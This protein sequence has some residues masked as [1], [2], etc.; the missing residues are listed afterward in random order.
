MARPRLNPDTIDKI[1]KTCQKTFTISFYLR[2]KRTYC[3]K[4]CANH[5]PEIIN[6]MVASQTKTFKEKYGMHPMKTEETKEN[7]KKSVKATHGVEWASQIKGWYDTVKKNNLIKHGVEHY[8]NLDAIKKTCMEK[9]GV[10]NYMQ[11]EEYMKKYKKTCMKKY[12]V[13]HASQSKKFKV[14]HYKNMFDK[15][16]DHPKF[17]NFKPL[18]K[19]TEYEGAS[20]KKYGFECRRCG[21]RK[22]HTL[23]CGKSP[24]CPSCDKNNSSFFQK[25]IYDFINNLFD[26]QKNIEI[27]DRRILSPKEIDIV[28]PDICLGIE[29]NGLVW[30]SEVIGRKQKTYHLNKNISA[31]AK[32]YRLIHV[33]ENE[34]YKKQEILKSMFRS[35]LGKTP[36]RIHG[37]KCTIKTVHPDASSKF[38]NENHIQGVDHSSVKIGLY[39]NNELVSLMTFVKSRFDKNIE[40][41]L[42]RFCNKLNTHVNGGASKLLSHF[43]KIYNPNNIVSYSD[44]RYFDGKLYVNLGFRFIANTRP[45]YFYIIDNYQTLQ[46]R[47]SWQ[48]HLLH[49][50]LNNFDPN[51][52]EWENMKNNGFDRIWDCGNSKWVWNKEIIKKSS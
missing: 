46:N 28:I 44:R 10:K 41:E 34:W 3:S 8:N 39:M 23:D 50:N 29:C 38:L 30:H 24:I 52:T 19:F 20:I 49:K 9:Y 47:I 27:N 31:M 11:T 33:F 14:T 2:N 18:F 51:L 21:D 4:K 5:D 43:I 37:R 36:D 12:G 6:K 32:G 25:E 48:K 16:M 45:S 1:C 35:I 26:K 7:L 15:F 42:S 22:Q 17:Q 13:P 40:W